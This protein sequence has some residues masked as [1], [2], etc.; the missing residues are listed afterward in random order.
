MEV[1]RLVLIRPSK[2]RSAHFAVRV[3]LQLEGFGEHV[4][5]HRLW[6]LLFF[7]RD[8]DCSVRGEA[9]LLTFNIGNQG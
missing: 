7:H 5:S 2:G 4:R 3:P 6:G 9:N 8:S 1:A